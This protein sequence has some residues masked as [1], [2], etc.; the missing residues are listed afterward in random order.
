MKLNV[1]LDHDA[2]VSD[3][4]TYAQAKARGGVYKF[5]HGPVESQYPDYLVV[6]TVLVFGVDE[7]ST[8]WTE[9]KMKD[10]ALDKKKLRPLPD[11]CRLVLTFSNGEDDD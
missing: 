8:T 4:V 6:D 10:Q 5:L 11:G 1:K 2:A 9:K 3:E 7:D